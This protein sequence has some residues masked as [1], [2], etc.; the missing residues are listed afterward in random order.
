MKT[1]TILFLTELST[2]MNTLKRAIINHPL[3][4]LVHF[5]H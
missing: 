1:N 4:K 5:I 3:E 2:C